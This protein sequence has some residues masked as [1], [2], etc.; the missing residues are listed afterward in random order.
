M[1][2]KL[3]AALQSTHDGLGPELR[4]VY[5]RAWHV[6]TEIAGFVIQLPTMCTITTLGMLVVVTLWVNEVLGFAALRPF[7]GGYTGRKMPTRR[8]KLRRRT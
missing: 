1:L 3:G 2:E 6:T 7:E 8:A 4:G 5:N